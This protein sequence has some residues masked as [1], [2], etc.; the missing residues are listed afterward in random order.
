MFLVLHFREDA[1]ELPVIKM[2]QRTL[3]SF[4]NG[5]V[6][7]PLRG[8]VWNGVSVVCMLEAESLCTPC[9]GG[10]S[11][12]DAHTLVTVLLAESFCVCV[13]GAALMCAH[14]LAVSYA[15]RV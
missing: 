7:P 14:S 1:H 5:S 12:M 2:L 13:G 11:R 10:A 4:H 9:V 6:M 15:H 8:G 3:L